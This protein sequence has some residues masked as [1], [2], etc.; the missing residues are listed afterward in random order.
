MNSNNYPGVTGRSV[1][2]TVMPEGYDNEDGWYE[3]ANEMK[4][5]S[6]RAT[7]IDDARPRLRTTPVETSDVTMTIEGRSTI[8]L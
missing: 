4:I 1:A 5:G 7:I 6:R 8:K 3:W 2:S